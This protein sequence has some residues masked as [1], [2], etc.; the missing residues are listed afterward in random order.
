MHTNK[1]ISCFIFLVF[2]FYLKIGSHNLKIIVTLQVI[3][4]KAQ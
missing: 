1:H 3:E 4:I 2:Y